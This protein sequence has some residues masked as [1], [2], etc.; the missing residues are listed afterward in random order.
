MID[1][2]ARAWG[3]VVILRHQN[4]E[5]LVSFWCW[6]A[7]MLEAE[8]ACIFSLACFF[9]VSLCEK[10]VSSMSDNYQHNT[11]SIFTRANKKYAAYDN[12]KL[13]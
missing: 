13:T 2:G 7:P 6:L 8:S 1:D 12:L 11:F 3:H 9:W 4:D 5:N 10:L